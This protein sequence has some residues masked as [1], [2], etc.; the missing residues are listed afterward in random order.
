[1]ANPNGGAVSDCHFEYGSS[2]AYG[3]SV[4]CAALPGAGTSAVAVSAEVEGLAANSTY[5]FRIVASNAGGTSAGADQTFTTVSSAPSAVTATASA[6]TQSS[7]MLNASVNPNGGA[8][9]DCH[10]EYGT[11]VFYEASVPCSS[12][13]GSG[14]SAV[15]MSAEVEGL[16][17]NTT[18]HFRIVASNQGGSGSGADQTF[19]TVSSAPSAVTATAS[20]LTQS[21]AMLNASVNPNGS[22]VSDCHFEYGRRSADGASVACASLPGSGT[23]AVAVSAEVE[24]LAANTTYHFRIV[25]SNAGG[26]GTGG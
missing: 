26:S 25:T 19:T 21:S 20:A 9:S 11:S 15:A 17:A 16:A 5:H 24:G 4:P 22:A 2:S 23:S 13:P 18:Y 10:F 6:L 1:T 14:S 7:A 8:V 12:L 3:T